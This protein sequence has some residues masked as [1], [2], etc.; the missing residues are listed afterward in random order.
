[1]ITNDSD[2]FV[3]GAKTI[4]RNFGIDMK[5]KKYQLIIFKKKEFCFSQFRLIY[6]IDM[7]LN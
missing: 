1:V 2:C 6:M 4:I 5:V 7:K 3:Y